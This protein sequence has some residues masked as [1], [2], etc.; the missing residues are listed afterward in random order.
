MSAMMPL[1]YIAVGIVV[2]GII[3]WLLG[4][5]RASRQAPDSRLEAELRDQL[6]RKESELVQVRSQAADAATARA[7]AEARQSS[8]DHSLAELRHTHERVQADASTIREQLSTARESQSSLEARLAAAE[9]L[10]ADSR[11]TYERTISE[12]KAAHEKALLDLREA[13][14]ALSADALRQ[15][16]PEF[17]R[18]ATETL[19]KFQESAKGDLS[20]RQ[21][22]I[23]TLVEPLKQQLEVYQQRLAQS[24]TTQSAA[25]GEV[26]QHLETLAQQSQSLSSETLQL[27]RVL[28]S[29]QA[30]GRWGEETLRRVVEA[31]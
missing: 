4:V 5:R 18:F 9:K 24:E 11:V 1:I 30:R 31:A 23:A 2:G 16:Q 28:S 21:Q 12:V 22:A 3:G 13:F 6:A 10:L 19:G 20:Q 15:S 14:K 8:S 17:L 26:R 29:N 27:R 25:I 7:A